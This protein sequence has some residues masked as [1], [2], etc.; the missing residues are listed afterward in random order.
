[1]LDICYNYRVT[2]D[3]LFNPVKSRLITFGGSNPKAIC[4]EEMILLAGAS[5][6]SRISYQGEGKQEPWGVLPL[7]SL[8]SKP[9]KSSYEFW[10]GAVSSRS[11]VLGGAPPKIEFGAY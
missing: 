3:I 10:R 11:G 7:P 9:L 4:D 1:M 6:L 5:V 8:R 2:W